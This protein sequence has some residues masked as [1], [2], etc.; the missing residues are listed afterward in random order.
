MSETSA[1]V[2]TTD[3]SDDAKQQR[4]VDF[5][6]D[7][8]EQYWGWQNES[9]KRGRGFKGALTENFLPLLGDLRRI[10][11]KEPAFCSTA[12]ASYHALCFL[13]R[14]LD[15]CPPLHED[16]DRDRHRMSAEM[17]P[18]V[19]QL[20]A[21]I[22]S[23]DEG[24]YRDSLVCELVKETFSLL[25]KLVPPAVAAALTDADRRDGM[26]TIV[27]FVLRLDTLV[28][29]SENNA[30]LPGASGRLAVTLL[31]PALRALAL[32]VAGAASP[33]DHLRGAAERLVRLGPLLRRHDP[34]VVEAVL[35][36]LLALAQPCARLDPA[37]A[38]AVLAPLLADGGPVAPCLL[39]LLAGSRIPR[40]HA[41][42]VAVV[43]ALCVA[44]RAGLAALLAAEAPAPPATPAR[45]CSPPAAAAAAGRADRRRGPPR[46]PRAGAFLRSVAQALADEGA[47]VRA[48]GVLS[49]IDAALGCV[50]D[51][52][53][54]QAARAAG[55]ARGGGG[56]SAGEGRNAPADSDAQR[57]LEEALAMEDDVEETELR[58]MLEHDEEALVR[59]EEAY[60]RPP[61]PLHSNG[62]RARGG[63][64]GCGR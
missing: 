6:R 5:F 36:A 63:V 17:A 23:F 29:A 20:L 40:V 3:D 34:A 2:D 56:G 52:H 18:F 59:D 15:E 1:A 53:Q 25:D 10:A 60:F 31:Q 19:P 43:C 33:A 22:Q 8:G 30:G 38:D 46:G 39:D 35:S 58:D 27:A 45:P 41:L 21:R 32:F 13:N 16:R 64:G 4:L 24:A 54:A 44:T 62:G 47:L 50:A 61:P 14:G 42:A 12:A 9:A 11:A 37:A 28:A 49:V 51:G 26:D 55:G 48:R 57:R 7:L